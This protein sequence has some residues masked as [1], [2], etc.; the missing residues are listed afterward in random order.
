MFPSI[1]S[2]ETI[3]KLKL[4][5]EC[6]IP[7]P[8]E[9]EHHR[10]RYFNFFNPYYNLNCSA[11]E[12]APWGF[13]K[14]ATFSTLNVGLAGTGNQTRATCVASS[15]NNRWAIHYTLNITVWEHPSPSRYRKWRISINDKNGYFI[16]GIS[17]IGTAFI[18]QA[19]SFILILYDFKTTWFQFNYGFLVLMCVV[20][21]V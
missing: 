21:F 4:F 2:F 19:K 1:L 14:R 18:V 8:Q 15:G 17:Y 10:L 9:L 16:W 12:C 6:G 3:N 20:Y 11:W 13:Q 7:R 5:F